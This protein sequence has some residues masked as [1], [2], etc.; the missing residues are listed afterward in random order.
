MVN[1]HLYVEVALTVVGVIAGSIPSGLLVSVAFGGGDLRRTGSG[2]IGT[3][4]ALRVLGKKA[5]L[6][7]LIGDIAKGAIPVVLARFAE[8]REE[9]LLLVGLGAIVG[10]IYSLFLRFKGGK[11]VATSFGVFLALSP[12]IALTSLIIWG[13]AICCGRYSSVGALAA[14]S[15]LPVVAWFWTMN[16]KMLIFTLVVS[17]LVCWQHK[18][19]IHRL[20]QGLENPIR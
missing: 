10:H 2:N 16:L 8:V 7:T 17:L 13:V 3:T 18:E 12:A 1:G 14:F 4:N 6:F 5:A 19:N 9:A 11:G 15:L 20:R